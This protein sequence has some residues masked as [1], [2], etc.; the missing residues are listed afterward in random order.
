MKLPKGGENNV[1]GG[2]EVLLDE[3]AVQKNSQASKVNK[4]CLNSG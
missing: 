4:R 3:Q 2:A 1:R